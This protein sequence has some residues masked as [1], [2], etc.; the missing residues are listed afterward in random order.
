MINPIFKVQEHLRYYFLNECRNE[1]EVQANILE[2]G[3][4]IKR[5]LDNNTITP[6]D[7]FDDVKN[8]IFL[9]MDWNKIKQFG[10]KQHEH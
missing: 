2:L 3:Y 6:F 1:I 4:A 7:N 9:E 8:L 5:L 10:V